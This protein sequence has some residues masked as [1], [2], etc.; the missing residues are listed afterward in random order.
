[1]VIDTSAVL[2]IFFAE[3]HARWVVERIE[4]PVVGP[5]W[6]LARPSSW[7]G[8]ATA[9]RGRAALLSGIIGGPPDAEHARQA[10]GRSPISHQ[11]GHCFAYTF[12]RGR[13]CFT[14]DRGTAGDLALVLPG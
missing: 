6:S 12:G 9:L 8:T 13:R 5:G 4:P 2:A 1:M 10:A 11:P 7:S 14:L 3:P